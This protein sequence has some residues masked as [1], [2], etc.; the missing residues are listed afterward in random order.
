MSTLPL[1]DMAKLTENWVRG[2]KLPRRNILDQMGRLLKLPRRSDLNRRYQHHMYK[3]PRGS[4]LTG[5]WH[6]YKLPRGSDLDSRR[7]M[8]KLPRKQFLRRGRSF[9]YSM[10]GRPNICG[11]C[12]SV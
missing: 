5:R 4:D 12:W 8:Y 7:R 2:T 10:P 9:L 3:L 6:M 1:R 11:R